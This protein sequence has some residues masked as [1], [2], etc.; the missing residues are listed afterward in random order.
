VGLGDFGKLHTFSNPES[1][2]KVLKSSDGEVFWEQIANVL[3]AT[4]SGFLIRTKEGAVSYLGG[5][6]VA[7]VKADEPG[8]APNGE[9]HHVLTMVNGAP[10]FAPL[11]SGQLAGGTGALDL[12]GVIG[13]SVGTSGVSIQAPSFSLTNGNAE[14]TV[15]AVNV[16]ATFGTPGNGGLD[17]GSEQSS[18]WYY[19]YVVS[20]G[21]NTAAII[22]LDPI[23]PDLTATSPVMT[24]WA[25]AGVFRNDGNSNIVPFLQRG[26]RIT[27]GIQVF[28][29]DFTTSN[30][31][32][33]VSSGIPLT[34]IIPPNTKAI[35]GIAGG[36]ATSGSVREM[37]V[38]S[39]L[40]GIG[41]QWIGSC[42][43]SAQHEGWKHDVG[44]FHD[45][46]IAV[47]NAPVIYASTRPNDA[48]GNTSQK[49]KIAITSYVI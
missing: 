48:S 35:S 9:D 17:V 28:S 49:R 5:N 44:T 47:P 43:F 23:R 16:T 20:N 32:T 10:A 30:I 36:S 1:V 12:S 41:Q 8:L 13:E 7:I 45:L 18:K 39:T 15:Q 42:N 3:P 27:T 46:V 21:T 31:L 33:A 11:P 4:G 25:L 26:R 24:H 22:S 19:V 40:S 6:G 38:A 14:I 34:S 2:Q 29:D 37:S